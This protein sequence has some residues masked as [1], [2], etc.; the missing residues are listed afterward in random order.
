MTTYYLEL[1]LELIYIQHKI[2]SFDGN[3]LRDH[4]RSTIDF[5]LNLVQKMDLTY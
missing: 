3:N 1:N 5:F 4:D 2:Y